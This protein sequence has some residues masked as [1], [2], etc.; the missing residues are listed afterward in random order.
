MLFIFR[1]LCQAN[2]FSLRTDVVLLAILENYVCVSICNA[3]WKPLNVWPV[4]IM[5]FDAAYSVQLSWDNSCLQFTNE[6][7]VI[8]MFTLFRTSFSETDYSQ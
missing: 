7:Q 5:Y 4:E 6:L 1:F 8:Q 3:A 2:K